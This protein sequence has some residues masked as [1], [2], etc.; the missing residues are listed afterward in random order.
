M[1]YL[2]PIGLLKPDDQ[3]TKVR[4]R[5]EFSEATIRSNQHTAIDQRGRT[6]VGVV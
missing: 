6:K 4:D 5:P 1:M 2:Q 3:N